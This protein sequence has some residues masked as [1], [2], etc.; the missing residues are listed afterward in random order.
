MAP[1]SSLLVVLTILGG[2]AHASYGFA[3]TPKAPLVPQAP[4]SSPAAEPDVLPGFPR[5]PD[6]PRSLFEQPSPT[7]AYSCAPLPG[8]YFERDPL[9]DPPPL[10]PPG[11]FTDAEIGIIVPH[12]KNRLADMVTIPGSAAPDTVHVPGADLNWTAAPHFE[13]G[14]RLPSGFGEFSLSYRF[15]TTEGSQL[16]IGP[17]GVAALKSRLT[18]NMGDLDYASREFWTFQCP[19]CYLKWRFGLRAVGTYFDARCDEPFDEAAAGSGVFERKTSNNFWG[20]GPH[21]ALEL[22]RRLQ[23]S[24]LSFVGRVDGATILGRIRQNFFEESTTPGP[25]G[26]FLAGNTRQSVSQD[27]PIINVFAGFSWQ[28]P[29][30][31]YFRLYAGYEYE[32]WWN[33]GRDSSTLS[34]GELSDQGIVLGAEFNF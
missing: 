9:L 4:P 14:Y 1:R 24:G 25:N 23:G 31:E 12:V 22:T 5:V 10:P 30:Y 28:P 17:D 7:P 2:I 16:S 34:R 15:F 3:Q 18:V 26:Q 21:M 32:Y 20:L 27:V 13:V 8:P 19:H 6:A 29:G 11:W 33:I